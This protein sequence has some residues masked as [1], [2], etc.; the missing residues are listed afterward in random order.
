MFSGLIEQRGTVTR[1]ESLPEG[2]RTLYIACGSTIVSGISPK[3]SVNIN[4]VCLTVTAIDG[5][6]IRFDV[7]PETLARST[8][9][10]WQKGG[11]VNLELALRL[12]DRIGGHFVYGHV[13]GTTRL[14]SR[15]A[16]GQGA[17]F[18]FESPVHLA[19]FICE[20][21]FVALDGVSLTV[22]NVPAGQ[23]E[24]AVI[25][26]TLERTT[27]GDLAAG[28]LVNLEVDPVARYAVTALN[29][30]VSEAEAAEL[31]WAY[32]I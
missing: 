11:Q 27:L 22:A 24:V 21:A 9:A 19:R 28:D 30:H 20:K 2:G 8:I 6:V 23:F 26:A 14:I 3:D 10:S 13:D 25:P 32:E 15:R 18:T 29:G 31:D 5:D 1:N 17:R 12:G 16:E 7:V 4:G